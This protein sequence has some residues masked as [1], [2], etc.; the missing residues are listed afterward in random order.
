MSKLEALGLLKRFQNKE[1]HLAFEMLEPLSYEAYFSI[2]LL[3]EYL[4]GQIG[5]DET[6]KLKAKSE[7]KTLKG[8]KE[9]T[10]SFDEV[11]ETSDGITA[12]IYRVVTPIETVAIYIC[13]L[14]EFSIILE[15]L[16]SLFYKYI[17]FIL[18]ILLSLFYK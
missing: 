13:H 5:L 15:E 7:K 9:V 3:S 6:N 18:H 14:T 17:I 2:P 10:K 16:L 11:Y 4:T 1:N 12:N 8:Y